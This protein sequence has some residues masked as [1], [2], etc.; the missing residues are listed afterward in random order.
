MQVMLHSL[1][2]AILKPILCSIQILSVVLFAVSSD[3]QSCDGV[4]DISCSNFVYSESTKQG[5]SL[6]AADGNDLPTK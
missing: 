1:D 5:P 6:V 3:K 2:T 4:E